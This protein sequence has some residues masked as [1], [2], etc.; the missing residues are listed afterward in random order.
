MNIQVLIVACITLLAF[1]AHVIGG[2]KENASL[3]PKAGDFKLVTSWKQ[4]MCAFQMLSVDLLAVSVTLFTVPLT[5]LIPVEKEVTLF[6]SFLF[7]LWGIVWLMQLAWLKS[8][9]KSYL[10][11][12]QW[13]F[14]FACS[15]LLY[16]GA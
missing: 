6:L 15:G 7:L 12:P 9:R 8:N 13:V 2:T 4:S 5:D 11:L 14:W 16:W 1:I 3:V 10:Y